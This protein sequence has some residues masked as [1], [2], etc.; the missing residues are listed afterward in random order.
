MEKKGRLCCAAFRK[1]TNSC[2]CSIRFVP[3]TQINKTENEACP[4]KDKQSIYLSPPDHNDKNND[5]DSDDGYDDDDSNGE[6][7]DGV[8]HPLASLEGAAAAAATEQCS[9]EGLEESEAGNS[10]RTSAPQ[11]L[12]FT[13]FLKAVAYWR[14]QLLS[15]EDQKQQPL[16]F[17]NY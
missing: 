1:R 7:D 10:D 9:G 3:L 14:T 2:L 12:F 13:S 5:N 15:E 17:V 16:A 11:S 4:A 6:D 8:I